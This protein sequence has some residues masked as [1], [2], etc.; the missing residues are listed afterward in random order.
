MSETAGRN[1]AFAQVVNQ[2]AG[3]PAPSPVV[4][5][6]SLLTDGQAEA[7][8][9]DGYL[10]LRGLVE[11]EV[12]EEVNRRAVERVRE[13][14]TGEGTNGYFMKDGSFTV[15][16]ENFVGEATNPEDRTSKLYNLHRLDLFAQLAMESTL[17][18]V[19]GAV[20][21]PDVDC[22]NSQFIFKNPGA[23]GQPWHQDS[24]YF[25]FDRSPQV[26]A[27]LATSAATRD[28][29][30]LFVAPGSHVEPLHEHVPD[31]RPGANLGYV[32]V[33]DHDFSAAVPVLM[34]PGDMLVFHSFLMHRSDDNRSC[35]RRTA[36]VC[37]YGES[38][39]STLGA[40]SGTID[41][42]TIRRNGR[43]VTSG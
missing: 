19:L 15:P 29:G 36:F 42:M 43:P 31:R 17:H 26:G 34:D 35:A 13:I 7:W 8:E 37:H 10:V 11:P 32:E 30:C 28:N 20:L 39:T 24:L 12:C 23:W 41:W 22:F 33:I 6:R 1:E 5:D 4:R 27:W 21:G 25:N 18:G 2:M 14:A 3:R 9:T 16:E 38:G 40:A